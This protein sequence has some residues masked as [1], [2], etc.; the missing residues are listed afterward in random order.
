M[1]TTPIDM[2]ACFRLF[3]NDRSETSLRLDVLFPVVISNSAAALII[4]ANPLKVKFFIFLFC[5]F[6]KISVLKYLAKAA[7][8]LTL[9]K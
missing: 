8:P 4:E 6:Q 3:N 5:L 1:I 2:A 7:I 9:P